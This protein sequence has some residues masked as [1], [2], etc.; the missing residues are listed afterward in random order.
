MLAAAADAGHADLGK[1]ESFISA[2][3]EYLQ[4]FDPSAREQ[5][6]RVREIIREVLPQASEKI[7]YGIPTFVVDGRN[8]VHF[9]GWTDHL[10]IYPVPAGDAAFQAAITGHRAGKGT[11]RFPLSEPLP[12]QLIRAQVLFLL[13]ERGDR[14]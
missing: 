13:A 8:L 4:D 7:A 9:G 6:K 14:G 10:S 1:M 3:D 12:E 2:I 5:L 11:L